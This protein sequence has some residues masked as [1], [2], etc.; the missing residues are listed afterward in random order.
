MLKYTIIIV[1]SLINKLQN[2]LERTDIMPDLLQLITDKFKPCNFIE[3][4]VLG[5]SRA[6]NTASNNSD[7]DIGI[8]YNKDC[9][10]YGILNT[11]A[12]KID[13]KHRPNLICHEGEW[14]NWV[15]CGGWLT[16]NNFPVDLILRD[17]SRVK[18]CITQTDNGNISFHYQ[19]GHPHAYLNVMY[20]GELSVSKILFAKNNDFIQLKHH[21]EYYPDTLQKA[22]I[23]FAMFEAN[24][25]CMLA[26]KHIGNDDLYYIN[27]HIFRSISSLNQVLFALNRVYC[28]N[29]KKAT[30]RINT[31]SKVP[32]NY[33]ARINQIL[34]LKT[35]DISQSL[36]LLEQ[37]CREVE[38]MTK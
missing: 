4:I 26:Q 38:N 23:S 7:Y 21:A 29:E 30:L 31:F 20:R 2:T 8:Y 10:D 24:F 22:L 28:L 9:I 12:A 14:G 5:G 35:D 32:P 25:S 37:L 27:G 1:S 13:D 16:V 6:T 34:Q 19:T 3:G 15:N 36:Y 33:H 11:I 18:N 17:I